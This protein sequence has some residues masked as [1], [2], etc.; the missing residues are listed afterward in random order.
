M[1]TLLDFLSDNPVT[2]LMD[3]M[4]FYVWFILAV[5]CGFGAYFWH[6]INKTKEGA[7]IHG[8]IESKARHGSISKENL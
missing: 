5:G 2:N 4:P 3:S 6:K 7:M 8:N 1:R